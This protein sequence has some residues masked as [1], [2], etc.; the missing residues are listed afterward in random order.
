MMSFPDLP[1]RGRGPAK[2]AG[3]REVYICDP[4]RPTM[5]PVYRRDWL[6]AASTIAG[7]ALIEEHGTTTVLFATD[8]CVVAPSGELIITVGEVGGA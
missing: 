8:K 6:G 1:D 3:T 5:C 7:P 4:R 2:P